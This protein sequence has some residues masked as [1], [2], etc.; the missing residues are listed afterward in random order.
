MVMFTKG[1][2]VPPT[3]GVQFTP[4]PLAIVGT[5]ELPYKGNKST[6]TNLFETRYKDANGIVYRFPQQ[7]LPD[8]DILEGM[9][10]IQTPPSPGITTMH[11]IAS[12]F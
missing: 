9:F 8:S 2:N 10:I 3:C 4:L 5:D 1:E 11:N 12:H 6:A 7:W